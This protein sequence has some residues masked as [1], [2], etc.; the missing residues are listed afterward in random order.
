MNETI[1]KHSTV[2]GTKARL[3]C[4]EMINEDNANNRQR[5][6]ALMLHLVGP[7]VQYYFPY[8][9]EHRRCEGLPVDALN[10]YFAPKVDTMYARHCFRQLT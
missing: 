7:D 3:V 4:D 9:A 2:M 5:R 6:R 10:A 8:P 1:S